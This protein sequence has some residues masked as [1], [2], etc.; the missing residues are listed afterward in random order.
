M[1]RTQ[2]PLTQD[3]LQRYERALILW[4]QGLKKETAELDTREAELEAREKA[5]GIEWDD[6]DCE[7]IYEP[8]MVVHQQVYQ[9]IDWE[10][11]GR[12][13]PASC[14]RRDCPANPFTSSKSGPC[15]CAKPKPVVFDD[16]GC[17]ITPQEFVTTIPPCGQ[18]CYEGGEHAADCAR[19]IYLEVERLGNL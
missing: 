15:I 3:E 11:I 14:H 19:M 9:G 1:K 13:R 4:E 10:A 6:E 18:K 8:A 16:G 7:S 2:K 12:K 17:T 5:L